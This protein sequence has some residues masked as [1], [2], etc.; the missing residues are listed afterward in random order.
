MDTS[1]NIVSITVI[2]GGSND[3]VYTKNFWEHMTYDNKVTKINKGVSV[4]QWDFISLTI[5]VY[6][7]SLKR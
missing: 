1:F 4:I 5:A 3:L 6:M 2:N 7:Q